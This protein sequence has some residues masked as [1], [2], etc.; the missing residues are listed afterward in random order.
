[1][2][3]FLNPLIDVLLTVNIARFRP[4]LSNLSNTVIIT[5]DTSPCVAST[6]HE[7]KSNIKRCHCRCS[8]TWCRR[9][10][11]GTGNSIYLL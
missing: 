9:S 1:V 5:R 6:H 11:F 4:Q 3:H 2:L 10:C 8:P 7:Y